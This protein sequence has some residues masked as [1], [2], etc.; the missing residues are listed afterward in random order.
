MYFV[1][2][3]KFVVLKIRPNAKPTIEKS[4]NVPLCKCAIYNNQ[5]I[6][7]LTIFDSCT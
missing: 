1:D 3:E 4:F 7:L 2:L 6:D 5:L